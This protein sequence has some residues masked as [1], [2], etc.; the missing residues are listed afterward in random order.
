MPTN[1]ALGRPAT[2]SSVCR[3]SRFQTV[4]QDARTANTGTVS[5]HE[6]FHTDVEASPWW[7]VELPG[8]C[9]LTELRLFN[10]PDC[11][12]RLRHFTVLGS[13]DGQRWRPLFSK[14]DT[15]VFGR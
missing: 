12:E 10:R 14:T 8:L 2:Q 5:G 7:Q 4:E 9:L 15:T 6:W 1:L 13:I 3:W 11:A